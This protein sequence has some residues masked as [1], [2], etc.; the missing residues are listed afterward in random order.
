MDGCPAIRRSSG[1]RIWPL[2][3]VA[4]RCRPVQFTGRASIVSSNAVP[5]RTAPESAARA[6]LQRTMAAR[7]IRTSSAR[8]LKGD[9]RGSQWRVLDGRT[10]EDGVQRVHA[11]YRIRAQIHVVDVEH[12]GH[13]Q[14]PHQ[15][16]GM[17]AGALGSVAACAVVIHQ[18]RSSAQ[19]ISSDGNQ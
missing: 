18:Q 4:Q 3:A 9:V 16:R 2:T 19:R 5:E 14:R 13:L 6:M 7:P 1:A 10:T 11:V 15:R 12:Y 17:K 8:P